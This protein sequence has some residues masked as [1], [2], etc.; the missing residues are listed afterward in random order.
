VA[1]TAPSY[2]PLIEGN[3]IRC[4]RCRVLDALGEYKALERVAEFEQDTAQVLKHTCGHV[5]APANNQVVAAY[6]R[7]DLIPRTPEVAIEIPHLEAVA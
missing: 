1:I 2:L 4:P 7:G 5:F 6:L 3:R